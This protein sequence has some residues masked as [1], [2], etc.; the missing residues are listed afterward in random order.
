[1]EISTTFTNASCKILTKVTAA[2]GLGGEDVTWTE[3][4]DTLCATKRLSMNNKTRNERIERDNTVR[5]Y[6]NIPVTITRDNRIRLDSID[7][8]LSEPN[9]VMNQDDVIQV[10]A[11]EVI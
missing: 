9:N 3:S 10:D 1:M 5:F 8:H 11:V 4:A 6:F 2:D 7:Y